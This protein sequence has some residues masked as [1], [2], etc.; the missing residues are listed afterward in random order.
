MVFSNEPIKLLETSYVP[1]ASSLKTSPPSLPTGTS[2][3]CYVGHQYNIPYNL[4]GEPSSTCFQPWHD[5]SNVL[6]RQLVCHQPLQTSPIT[7]HCQCQKPQT[8]STQ[9][10]PQWQSPHLT[11]HWKSIFG[12]TGQ[13]YTRS[14]QNHWHT[15][16]PNQWYHSYSALANFCWVRQHSPIAA[17]FWMLQLRTRMSYLGH[18][19]LLTLD[20][21]HPTNIKMTITKIQIA[22]KQDSFSKTFDLHTFHENTSHSH[23]NLRRVSKSPLLH[24]FTCRRSGTLDW[25][26]TR[27]TSAD[28]SRLTHTIL[29][30]S[31]TLLHYII[32][33]SF[34]TTGHKWWATQ[35]NEIQNCLERK[36]DKL[37]EI[38]WE[39]ELFIVYA[40]KNRDSVHNPL[41]GM[42]NHKPM[43]WNLWCMPTQ[44]EVSQVP[45]RAH[46]CEKYQYWWWR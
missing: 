15:T 19:D 32:F 9:I 5:S 30:H 17:I 42:E 26:V 20:T 43:Q 40:R 39:I 35:N 45:K 3:A 21:R 37:H 29:A 38:V 13:T 6:C 24:P 12:K 23:D 46:R 10:L 25:R 4:K 27:A 7:I 36:C 44:N 34:V 8:H 16:T 18:Y 14:F 11:W 33:Q 28:S 2:H 22:T 1:V 41:R 31:S